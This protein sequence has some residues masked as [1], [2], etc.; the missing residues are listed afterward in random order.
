MTTDVGGGVLEAGRLHGDQLQG[1]R[2]TLLG[3]I[4][5][6]YGLGERGIKKMGHWLK[7]WSTRTHH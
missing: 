2:S 4:Q 1:G 6:L 7:A 5:G 3:V